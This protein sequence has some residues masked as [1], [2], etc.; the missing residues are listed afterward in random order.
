MKR[1][2][3]FLAL[4]S[5]VVAGCSSDKGDTGAT[6]SAST[7]SAKEADAEKEAKPKKQEVIREVDEETGIVTEK[8]KDGKSVSVLDKDGKG[9]IKSVDKND[10]PFTVDRTGKVPLSEVGMPEYPGSKI[11][12]KQPGVMKLTAHGGWQYNIMRLTPDE[13]AKITAF[14]KKA[15]KDVKEEQ[16][17]DVTLVRGKS[18]RGDKTVVS[19]RKNPQNEK[20]YLVSVSVTRLDPKVKQ[21]KPK[22]TDKPS[23]QRPSSGSGALRDPGAK[24][25][26]PPPPKAVP[27]APED[28]PK[29][30]PG[31]AADQ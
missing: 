25:G 8:T 30:R 1:F 20:E 17:G 28:A 13:P 2:W 31:A 10:R 29:T 18:M 5:L 26:L 6:D 23:I 12:D 7:A 3:I 19:I 16:N 15:M 24:P 4:A 27:A 9:I 11:P 14:Y 22:E 21:D